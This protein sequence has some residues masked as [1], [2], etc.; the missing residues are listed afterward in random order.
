MKN[1]IFSIFLAVFVLSA[2]SIFKC[3]CENISQSMPPAVNEGDTANYC[4]QIPAP[5]SAD[6]Q[7]GETMPDAL[8][9]LIK[10]TMNLPEDASSDYI[11]QTAFWRCMDGKVYVCMTGANLPCT[12]KA[13][14]SRVPSAA[15]TDYCSE[16]PS[17]AF[18]PAYITGRA[19]IYDWGCEEGK[20]VAARQL[21]KP[22][23]QGFIS[24]IWFELESDKK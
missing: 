2:C 4:S 16:N 11:R 22:D 14:T 18:I 8:I 21:F 9:P 10:K 24:D 12:E 15:M 23:K 13:D 6:A 17:Q 20:P 19:T 1:T 7:N 3:P 5:D